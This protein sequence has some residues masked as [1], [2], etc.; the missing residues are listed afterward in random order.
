MTPP[1]RSTRPI[2]SRK[3][4]GN[5]D[6]DQAQHINAPDPPQTPPDTPTPF[7][8]PPNPYIARTARSAARMT[9]AADA[10]GAPGVLDGAVEH[11]ARAH[12]RLGTI[13]A[14]D[15]F[16][17]NDGH[18]GVL[19]SAPNAGCARRSWPLPMKL[20][21]RGGPLKAARH[22]LVSCRWPPLR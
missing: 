19:V 6:P 21:S 9:C 15:L 14:L 17:A 2:A 18:D 1:F 13:G 5:S 8:P 12:L 20:W 10:T 22:L 3:E 11:D 4:S 16:E 7:S